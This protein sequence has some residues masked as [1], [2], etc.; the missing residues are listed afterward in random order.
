MSPNTSTF[1]G[2]TFL[3]ELSAI[4]LS[5]KITQL[6][7]AETISNYRKAKKRLFL[8][9]YDGTLTPIVR[10]PIDA[11]PSQ[12]LISFLKALCNDPRNYVYIVSGRDRAFLSNFFGALPLGMSCEHGVFFRPCGEAKDWETIGSEISTKW[13]DAVYPVLQEFASRTPG[14]MIEVKEVNLSWH[15]RNADEDFGSW[16][17][18]ELAVHLQ[19]MAQKLPIDVVHGKKV[20]EVRPSNINKGAAVQKAIALHPDFEFM[21]CVGDD[22]TDEGLA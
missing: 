7:F 3:A 11:V 13:K 22:R 6:N 21:L 17:A 14:S 20:I 18:K 9:D 2:S 5:F 15:Y 16:Q 8:F 19:D 10:N 4:E 1:W 12:R